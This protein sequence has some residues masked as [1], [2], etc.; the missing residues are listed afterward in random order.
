[1]LV[2]PR[3]TTPPR[4]SQSGSR[5]YVED[6]VIHESALAKLSSVG[7]VPSGFLVYLKG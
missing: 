3:A 7:N 6:P 2:V 4:Q 1:M 5:K